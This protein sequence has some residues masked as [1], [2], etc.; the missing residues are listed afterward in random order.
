MHSKHII[1]DYR[2]KKENFHF[3]KNVYDGSEDL[4][5]DSSKNKDLHRQ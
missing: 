2:T 1:P 3:K 4:H 5:T